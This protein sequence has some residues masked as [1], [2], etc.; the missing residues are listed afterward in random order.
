MG[1]D[2]FRSAPSCEQLKCSQIFRAWAV[3]HRMVSEN[4]QTFFPHRPQ[5]PKSCH[6]QAV[7]R[8]NSP[9][10]SVL[11][12]RPGLLRHDGTSMT[13]RKGIVCLQVPKLSPAHRNLGTEGPLM[14]KKSANHSHSQISSGVS[15]S[16]LS[17][18]TI[19]TQKGQ[20][21]QQDAIFPLPLTFLKLGGN[22]LATQGEGN[23]HSRHQPISLLSPYQKIWQLSP[24]RVL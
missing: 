7:D 11:T 3:C 24:I 21:T 20:I 14:E 17:H 23:D 1:Q 9:L 8:A 16:T 15:P 6:V 4:V 19:K 10:S 5:F 12:T 18:S 2:H 22:N 13:F